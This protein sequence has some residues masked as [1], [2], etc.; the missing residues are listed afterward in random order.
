MSDLITKKKT[1]TRTRSDGTKYSCQT[2]DLFNHCVSPKME[3]Y[4]NF[5]KQIMILGEAPGEFE[6]KKNLPWQGR[7]GRYLQKALTEFNINLF[8]DCLSLYAVYCRPKDKKGETRAPSNF[9]LDCCRRHVLQAVEQFKPKIIIL[10][11]DSAVYSL[12]GNRWKRDLGTI[13]KWRGWQIPDQDYKAWLC[14]TFDPN[15]VVDGEGA[16]EVIWKQD[17]EAAF[18]LIN[19]SSTGEFT[20]P[21][22]VYKEPVIEIIQDL[23]VLRTIKAYQIAF[24]Y[25]TTGL[26]PHA[27]GHRIIC[28]A[29]ADDENHAY[30]F[31]MPETKEERAPFIELLIN[32]EI[33][34]IAQNMKFEHAWTFN[35]LR[36]VVVNW[37]WDTM[38][39]TH[40]FDNRTGITSLKF[41]TYVQFG[42]IDYASE[43]TPFLQSDEKKNANAINKIYDLLQLPEGPQK[44]MKYCG[45]DAIHELRLANKQRLNFLPF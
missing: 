35:R 3:P 6:D 31:M 27:P 11:G 9:E 18:N 21:V 8:E 30:V 33:G 41:Q 24:D 39:A 7:V 17:L 2:C 23:S 40:V 15:Y 14:P 44:L 29:V 4:G 10:L 19:W 26:K 45:Y 12:I 43:I 36:V 28:C 5:K 20:I 42:V 25:E 1:G 22:P 13:T 32:P 38:L 37:I 16:E 34:K